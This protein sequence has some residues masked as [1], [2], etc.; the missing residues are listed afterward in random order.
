MTDADKVICGCSTCC[1]TDDINDAYNDKRRKLAA[2]YEVRLEELGD[3]TRAEKRTHSILEPALDKYK[4]AIFTGDNP[5]FD[6]RSEGIISSL[7]NFAQQSLGKQLPQTVI[8]F[9]QRYGPTS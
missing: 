9:P 3:S 7:C 5:H 8:F 2:L 1:D 6:M 4:S